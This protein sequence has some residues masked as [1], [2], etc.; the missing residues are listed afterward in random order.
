MS[1]TALVRGVLVVLGLLCASAL[2]ALAQPVP[3]REPG[4]THVFPAGGQRGTKFA[5]RVGTQCFP[6]SSRWQMDGAGVSVSP[7]LARE[8]QPHYET[9]AR[10]VPTETPI[11]FAREW[12]SVV[13]IAADAAV[14]PRLWCIHSARGG[15]GRRPFV[16]GDL[17]EIIESE[18]NSLPER[19]ES[20]SLP[21]TINGQ[22]AGE[23][24]VDYYRLT[25]EAG[26][27]VRCELAA[28]RLGSP[29]DA[30]IEIRDPEGG[31]A[32]V[33]EQRVGCDPI[34]TF[35]AAQSGWYTLMIANLGYYGGPEY[36][37]RATLTVGD[38][39]ESGTMPIGDP[40]LAIE[41]KK[42]DTAQEATLMAAPQQIVGC[43][44][45]PGDEDWWRL[46]TPRDAALSIVC[47]PSPAGVPTLPRLEL[48]DAQNRPLTQASSVDDAR[49]QARLEWRSAEE[50]TVLLR[51]RDVQQATRGGPEFQYR[52][53]VRVNEPD[54]E[55]RLAADYA[56]IVPGGKLTLDVAALRSGGLSGPIELVAEGLP[57]GVTA[58][59]ASIGEKKAAG[60]LVLTAAGDAQPAQAFLKVVGR[61]KIGERTI[62]RAATAPHQGHDPDGVSCGPASVAD[63]HFTVQHKPVFRLFCAEAYQ[64][65]HR[66]SVHPYL[67]EIERLD[68]FDGPVTLQIGDRQ[69]RDLDG[70]EMFETVIP[71]GA[72]QAFMPIYLPEDMHVNV[73]SQSQLYIQGHAVFMDRTGQ[74]QSLLVVSEKRNII[75][76]MPP[77]VKLKAVDQELAVHAGT[78]LECRLQL[79]RTPNF[80]GPMQIELLAPPPGFSAEPATIPANESATV[81]KVQVTSERPAQP[82]T[83]L[84]FRARGQLSTGTRIV[85]ETILHVVWK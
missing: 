42:D 68:G 65:G 66:G 26:Q 12:D 38:A 9:S 10:R 85:S 83:T 18:S 75:R 5:V 78:T 48:F 63:L 29:L 16:V 6:P 60:K 15:S 62:E 19:A 40:I 30:V 57:P 1:Q 55:L 79:E 7:V 31:R 41:A 11:Y 47:E 81:V 17:P 72:T 52:L 22:I 33:S 32:T 49:R 84:R 34:V 70:I 21:V 39:A 76:T 25:L 51:V 58:E 46:V 64:Y 8:A 3:S 44:E 37:Y 4:S 74:Q 50:Q 2:P 73:Q 45:R 61:A 24:D 59:A 23:R 56:S 13:E 14:G 54:F 82:Q 67:M 27:A 36:V 35:R 20:V 77:V 43:F 28:S 80:S 69:N 53:R 71:P